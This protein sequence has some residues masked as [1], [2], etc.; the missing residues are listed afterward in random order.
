MHMHIYR[1]KYTR[2]ATKMCQ[3][4]PYFVLIFGL[5]RTGHFTCSFVPTVS[6]I[7][8]DSW[9]YADMEY[10]CLNLTDDLQFS[11]ETKIVD[12][13]QLIS[14]NATN[15]NKRNM[16]RVWIRKSDGYCEG[17]CC[18][19]M[20]GLKKK[21]TFHLT[22]DLDPCYGRGICHNGLVGFTCKC[23]EGYMGL[24]CETGKY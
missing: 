20:T 11:G 6:I 12:G 3:V 23:N 10:G 2:S 13:K 18:R 8:L 15:I 19:N 17:N 16:T 22:C 1:S 5:I 24:R 4:L 14:V 7:C 21:R 9:T